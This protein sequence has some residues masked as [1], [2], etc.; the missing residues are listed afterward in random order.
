MNQEYDFDPPKDDIPAVFI[1]AD[2]R[3]SKFT[4]PETKELVVDVDIEQKE[5]N[6]NGKVEDPYN[7]LEGEIQ[8]EGI[9]PSL[10]KA[11]LKEKEAQTQSLVAQA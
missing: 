2:Q 1:N 3:I 7:I 4:V 6:D 5:Q 8:A 10:T 9:K 11:V